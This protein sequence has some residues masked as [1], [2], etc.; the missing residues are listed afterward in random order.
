MGWSSIC[1]RLLRRKTFDPN[2][3]GEGVKLNRC[4][5][6]FDLIFLGVGSTLGIGVYVRV[7][8][9]KLLNAKMINLYFH[10]RFWQA[11]LQKMWQGL[12]L[13]SRSSS[14]G[15][16]LVFPDFATLN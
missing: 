10:L 16:P 5:T 8:Y 7:I 9:K 2:E 12:P 14:Q 15:W 3:E 11:Q 4:L 13:L 6:L 1:N